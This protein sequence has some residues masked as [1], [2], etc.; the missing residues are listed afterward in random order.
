MV[1]VA[2]AALLVGTLTLRADARPGALP[3]PARPFATAVFPD[4]GNDASSESALVFRRIRA[5]GASFARFS[6]HWSDVAPKKPPTRAD[7]RDPGWSGYRWESVDRQVR[8]ATQSRLKVMLTIVE[9]PTWAAD[10]PPKVPIGP[11]N[12]DLDAL[13]DFVHAAAVR[14]G[15]NYRG[16]PRVRYWVA[17]NEPNLGRYLNPQF[18][19]DNGVGGEVYRALVNTFADAVHAVHGENM[20]IAGVT[21][22]FTAWTKNSKARW[23]L[24]PLPFMRGMLCL[25]RA[26]KPTCSQRAKFDIWSHHPYTSGGPTHHAY[27]A[28]DVS[29]GDLP[30][31]RA[32]LNAAI[33]YKKIVS[34]HRPEFWVTEF[35]W[36]T[37]P[38]D[39]EGIPRQL[40]GRWAAEALYRMWQSGVTV[41]TWY[42][43]RDGPYPAAPFQGGLYFRGSTVGRDRAKPAYR[44]FR[45]PFV[46][47]TR[48][49]TQVFVWGRTPTSRAGGVRVEQLVG[50]SW[51]RAGIVRTNRYGVFTG[52]VRRAGGGVFRARF[53]GETTNSFSLV[54]PR[55]RFYYPFGD[56]HP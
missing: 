45:F 14:Y 20:L 27:S 49:A 53:G 34:R 8:W 7:A 2:V 54:R 32:V 35:S 4:L 13:A 41:A 52:M 1:V 23:G 55:D 38:P 42:G 15:G 40:H 37:N 48:G 33:R 50:G 6:A 30:E 3:T 16:L 9:T 19:D 5:A 26:L 28:D 39:R 29:L 21:A 47:Y 18:V 46:A 25:S 17:W 31:M 44:A 43:M 11:A 12:I 10:Y 56:F 22:P 51:R 36:D 24:G